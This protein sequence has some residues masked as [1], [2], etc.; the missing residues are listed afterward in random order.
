VWK[1]DPDTR[2]LMPNMCQILELKANNDACWNHRGDK[3]CVGS[4]SGHVFIGSYNS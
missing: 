1:E 4:A 3:F 2:Q